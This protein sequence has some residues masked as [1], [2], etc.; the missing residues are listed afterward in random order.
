MA[1]YALR[2]ERLVVM[3]F[4]H[5]RV[6]RSR[7][8]HSPAEMQFAKV[9]YCFATTWTGSLPKK[10]AASSNRSLVH[11]GCR[12]YRRRGRPG[13]ASLPP[14]R[15]SRNRPGIAFA[16]PTLSWSDPGAGRRRLSPQCHHRRRPS[17]SRRL[18]SDHT[19]PGRSRRK[20]HPNH[21]SLLFEKIFVASV[22]DSIRRAHAGRSPSHPA[23]SRRQKTI[24]STPPKCST[25]SGPLETSR[26][27]QIVLIAS[28]DFITE[29]SFGTS[30]KRN[31]D[32]R[33]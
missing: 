9:P 17:R 8:N 7:L 27:S 33:A 3:H 10:Y 30:V 24:S 1:G 5:R 25:K 2:R 6:R 26:S 11:G 22:R 16:Q 31:S 14:K 12:D 28:L 13:S 15:S 18:P 23:L 29:K 21:L 19:D 32:G 4:F 20:S